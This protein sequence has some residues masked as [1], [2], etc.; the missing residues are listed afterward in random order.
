MLKSAETVKDIGVQARK[1]LEGLLREVSAI[2]LK[3]IEVE[4]PLGDRNIDVLARI[5]VANRPRMLV[6]EVKSSGQ[7]RYVRGALLQL[8][9]YVT[10]FGKEAI[11]VFI[12][13]YLSPEARALCKENG[14]G[15]LDLVG[16]A[17][18][19]FDNV[20]I[21]RLVSDRPTAE[22][23][24]LK[25]LFKPKSAQILRVMFRDPRHAWRVNDLAEMAGVSLGHTSNVRT[26]LLDHE[27]GELSESGLF[28]SNPDALLD[29][30]RDVYEPSENGRLGFY[31]TLHGSAFEE[32]AR[33]IFDGRVDK[34]K[35][36]LASF[37]AAQW[38]APYGRT[39]TQYFYAD[40]DGLDRLKFYL[41]LSP[42]AKGENVVVIIPKDDGIFRDT[43]DPSPGI[44]CTSPIQTYLDLWNAGERGREAAEHLRQM[45]LSWQT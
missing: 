36:A 10:H 23:R 7:P 31:T 14:V 38:Q 4:S 17:R 37:S 33:S 41:T 42:S 5:S 26:A 30:W 1:A 32:A 19:V 34:G 35:V 15:Y 40:D 9:N 16:N 6:C 8:R 28:L 11:A 20:Y 12:A 25:S 44:I 22:R 27:W 13:P 24:E 45:R 29:A 3:S 18:L 21:E 43:I 39:S 2:H